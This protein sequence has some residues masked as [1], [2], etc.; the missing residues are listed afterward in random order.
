[1]DK[2]LGWVVHLREGNG[3]VGDAAEVCGA[4]ERPLIFFY[5]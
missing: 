1:M 5:A 4:A 2:N 3:Q